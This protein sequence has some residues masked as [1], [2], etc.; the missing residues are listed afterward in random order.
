MVLVCRIAVFGQ[1]GPHKITN[2][3]H[4]DT[5]LLIHIRRIPS[6]GR[7]KTGVRVSILIGLTDSEA[8][9]HTR[10]RMDKTRNYDLRPGSV[11]TWL[12]VVS[13]P[14][15]SKDGT[16][17]WTWNDSQNVYI[18]TK[19]E[20][21]S[22]YNGDKCLEKITGQWGHHQW[23]VCSG[24]NGSSSRSDQPRQKWI[25]TTLHTREAKHKTRTNVGSRLGRNG[26]N[27]F[28]FQDEFINLANYLPL[29]QY[30]MTRQMNHNPQM[31]GN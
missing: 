5:T 7:H 2:L 14:Y 26:Q 20:E 11:Q 30:S 6:R 16:R 22:N 1:N 18:P 31:V 24:W 12:V 8:Q 25:Q 28:T 9:S 10:P 13:Q 29:P 4:S 27:H 23:Y 19:D 3:K 15:Q 17:C 21:V